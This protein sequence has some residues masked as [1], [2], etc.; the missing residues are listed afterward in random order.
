MTRRP[1]FPTSELIRIGILVALLVAVVF[2]K[3]RCGPAAESL[4]K[5]LYAPSDGGLTSPDAARK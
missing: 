2:M 5:T 1:K 4:F 3:S